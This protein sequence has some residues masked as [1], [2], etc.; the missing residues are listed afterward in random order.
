MNLLLLAFLIPVFFA[1]RFVIVNFIIPTIG[2]AFGLKEQKELKK[3][4]ESGFKI[5]YYLPMWIWGFELAYRNGWLQNPKLCW[6]GFPNIIFTPSHELYY[7]VQLSFYIFIQIAHVFFDVKRKDFWAMLIHHFVTIFLVSFSWY[8]GYGK[9]GVVV[10]VTMDIVD[11]FLELAK[12]FN[13]LKVTSLAN[14]FFVLLL[15]SWVYFRLYMFPNVALRTVWYDTIQTHI[16]EAQPYNINYWRCFFVALLV[17]QIL[18]IY[19]FYYICK[20]L[21]KMLTT[22]AVQDTTD[23]Q[24]NNKKVEKASLKTE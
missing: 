7:T 11:V 23:K 3:L 19:W 24:H 13:Y 8:V 15:I 4:S 21:Y 10:F 14:F 16:E 20:A 9:I 17:I 18:Q 1:L 6:T 5:G 12:F 2:R 22:G